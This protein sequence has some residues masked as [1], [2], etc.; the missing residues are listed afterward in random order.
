MFVSSVS[1]TT[2]V[3]SLDIFMLIV[4]RLHALSSPTLAE[5]LRS[6]SHNEDMC[7]CDCVYPSEFQFGSR[8]IRKF[9]CT[10][11]NI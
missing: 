11:E 2:F 6:I 5:S 8:N 7:R 1:V 4:V 9:L 10:R 3:C